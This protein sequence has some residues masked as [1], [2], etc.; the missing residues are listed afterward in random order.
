MD[1][2]SK[3]KKKKKKK[4]GKENRCYKLEKGVKNKTLEGV[5]LRLRK[6]D[7]WQEGGLKES[8]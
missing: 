7:W 4:A 6:A 1:M 2:V 5:E 8:L 3:K